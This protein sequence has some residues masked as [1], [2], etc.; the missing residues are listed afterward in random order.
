MMS[1]FSQIGKL[2]IA[3]QSPN[4]SS[5]LTNAIMV[6]MIPMVGSTLQKVCPGAA[7]VG[8]GVPQQEGK[9]TCPKAVVLH[10][11]ILSSF[12]FAFAEM[13]SMHHCAQLHVLQRKKLLSN[14]GAA[15]S[16]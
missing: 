1:L 4:P 6:R 5:H 13:I 8:R 9:A 12:L 14:S 16:K 10:P 7:F 2:S 11:S 15:L 3:V